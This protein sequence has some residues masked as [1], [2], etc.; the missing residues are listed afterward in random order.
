[1]ATTQESRGVNGDLW[2]RTSIDERGTDDLAT[3]IE[4]GVLYKR[5]GDVGRRVL[6]VFAHGGSDRL[7]RSQRIRTRNFDTS[8]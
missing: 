8:R 6:I 4:K 1:M 3:A 5:A 2:D 7:F